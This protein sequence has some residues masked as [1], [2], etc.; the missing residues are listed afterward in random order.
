MED[1][2][3]QQASLALTLHW[4]GPKYI[5]FKRIPSQTGESSLSLQSLGSTY[6]HTLRGD[7]KKM[8]VQ[9]IAALSY[10]RWSKWNY[11]LVGLRCIQTRATDSLIEWSYLY[12]FDIVFTKWSYWNNE[13]WLAFCPGSE[14][15]D[16]RKRVVWY[17][18]DVKCLC[19]LILSEF[20]FAKALH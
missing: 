8:L 20:A 3:A 6:Y 17:A 14:R 4:W 2:V 5:H 18:E 7:L 12:R 15:S 11:G 9:D 16:W 19:I 10:H 1:A 13:F